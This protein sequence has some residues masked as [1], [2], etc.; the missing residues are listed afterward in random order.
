MAYSLPIIS[1]F[2]RTPEPSGEPL[3]VGDLARKTGKTVRALHLYE[4]LGLLVPSQRSK[5]GYRL[6][7]PESVSRV[8]WINKLQEMGFS[9][10]AIREL[11]AEWERSASA[12]S[13]MKRV[14]ELYA[15]KLAETHEQIKKLQKL[16]SEL[17]ESIR[18]LETCDTCDPH[19]EVQACP[20]CEVHGCEDRAPDLVSGLQIKTTAAVAAIAA[21]EQGER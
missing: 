1:A 9:L 18:Y 8:T 5:G 21:N 17:T 19:R 14:H 7:G 6:Y 2:V 4:E 13:A 20:K 3:R 12:P 16:E 10:P 15:E 11:V